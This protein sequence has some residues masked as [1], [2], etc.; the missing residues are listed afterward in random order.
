MDTYRERKPCYNRRLAMSDIPPQYN[1]VNTQLLVEL[2]KKIV[3]IQKDIEFMKQEQV[4]TKARYDTENAQLKDFF[5]QKQDLIKA[6]L[7]GRINL[8][9]TEN[10]LQEK[11]IE[12]LISRCDALEHKNDKQV[13]NRWEQIK[14]Y[15]F[16]SLI[17]FIAAAVAYYI[18]HV[19]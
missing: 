4:S 7:E 5:L 11:Q 8:L 16:K 9:K 19:K 18:V 13:L 12:T 17:A 10:A 3:G 14:D 15:A 2:D 6:E 1:D